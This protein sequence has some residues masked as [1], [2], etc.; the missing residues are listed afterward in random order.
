MKTKVILTIEQTVSRYLFYKTRESKSDFS[1]F[2]EEMKES[3]GSKFELEYLEQSYI[4]FI[5]ARLA[6]DC[7]DLRYIYPEKIAAKI[8]KKLLESF[9]GNLESGIKKRYKGEFYFYSEIMLLYDN[10]KEAARQ[11]GYERIAE[12]FLTEILGDRLNHFM[13][14]FHSHEQG[15]SPVFTRITVNLLTSSRLNWEEL[16]KRAEVE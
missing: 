15:I 7:H 13:V 11:I 2:V 8:I 1:K 5:T 9:T 16:S 14:E 6:I 12:K 10:G 3:Y 4:D